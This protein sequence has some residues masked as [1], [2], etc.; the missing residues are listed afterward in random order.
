MSMD[1]PALL[2]N[3]KEWMPGTEVRTFPPAS[4]KELGDAE[5]L[6]KVK[7]PQELTE[8]LLYSN[9]LLRLIKHPQSNDLIPIENLIFSISK[10]I[11]VTYLHYDYVKSIKKQC[12]YTC[13]FFADNGCGESF[14]YKFKDDG[15]D[16]S[17]YIYYPAENEFIKVAASFDEW[18]AGWFSGKIST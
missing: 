12:L 15:E 3:L 9:G 10:I 11:E 1:F 2:G 16:T 13:I 6:L 17:I 8:Y 7:L 4:T 14:C 18:A 5:K